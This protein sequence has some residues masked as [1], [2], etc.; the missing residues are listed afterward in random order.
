MLRKKEHLQLEVQSRATILIH[1]KKSFEKDEC[2][3]GEF[4]KSK[5]EVQ[6]VVAECQLKCKDSGVILDLIV[7][8]KYKATTTI[9]IVDLKKRK[10]DFKFQHFLVDNQREKVQE[11]QKEHALALTQLEDVSA[12]LQMFENE[13]NHN[14]L[15]IKGL[16]C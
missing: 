2:K 3:L 13:G 14:S 15:W 11:G 12:E 8:E 10:R 5:D 1:L 7:V 16:L 9:I 4:G 6:Q